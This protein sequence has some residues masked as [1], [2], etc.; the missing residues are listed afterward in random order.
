M[1]NKDLVQTKLRKIQ[2]YLS[3]VEG[4]LALPKETILANLEKTRTLERNFQLV[5]DTMLDINIHFIRELELSS[6]DDLQSTFAILAD[7]EILPRDLAQKISPT[8]GLRNALVHGYEKIDKER[9]VESF[10]KNSDDFNV[11]LKLINE[12]LTKK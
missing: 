6:P 7:N 12:F 3:E 9:F 2:E 5:V 8:V 11:Y 4:I 1:L 10:I